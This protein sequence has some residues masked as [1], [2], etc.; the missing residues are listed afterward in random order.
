MIDTQLP[1]ILITNLNVDDNFVAA[2]DIN[3]NQGTDVN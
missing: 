1:I 3:K 2:A